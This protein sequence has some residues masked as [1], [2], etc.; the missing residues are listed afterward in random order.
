MCF[1]AYFS[2]RYAIVSRICDGSQ[3]CTCPQPNYEECVVAVLIA[4]STLIPGLE[5]PR[6]RP[7]CIMHGKE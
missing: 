5:A 1:Y 3:V 4:P 2:L 7:V 6:V